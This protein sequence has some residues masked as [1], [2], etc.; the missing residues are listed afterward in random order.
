[1][2]FGLVMFTVAAAGALL[3]AS[4]EDLRQGPAFGRQA[5]WVVL[6]L[7]PVFAVDLAVRIIRRTPALVATGEGLVFRSILGFSPPIPWRE[8]SYIGPVVMGKKL[9]LGIHLKDPVATFARF[10]TGMRLMHAKSHAA[11]VPNITFRAI[12]LGV[13]P[14]EAAVVLEGIR[15][16]K[17]I[18]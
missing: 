15:Q 2:F 4:P 17:E 7:C 9:Y 14:P 13:N 18:E 10:G 8:I 6:V 12:H 16:G 5:L 3:T 1:M 11:N